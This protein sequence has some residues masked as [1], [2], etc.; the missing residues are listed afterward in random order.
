MIKNWEFLLGFV[1]EPEIVTELPM[2]LFKKAKLNKRACREAETG[3]G[4]DKLYRPVFSNR[5][6]NKQLSQ[7]NSPPL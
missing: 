2:G 3:K 6:G 5:N 1:D 4:G 7:G